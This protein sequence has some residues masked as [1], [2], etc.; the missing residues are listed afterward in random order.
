MASKVK[1]ILLFVICLGVPLL[2][3]YVSSLISGDIR[4]AYDSMA[5]VPLSP[6]GGLFGIVW[7]AL[8]LLMG[9]ASYLVLQSPAPQKQKVSALILY[10]VQLLVNGVWS[11]VFF[12][13]GS[14]WLAF[15]VILALDLLVA[16]CVYRFRKICSGAAIFLLPYMVWILFATYLNIGFAIVN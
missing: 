6:P 11:I 4:S 5:K 10:G 3:G 12:R 13:A 14:L 1:R 7:P 15:A 8:Y 2:V 16:G 9:L